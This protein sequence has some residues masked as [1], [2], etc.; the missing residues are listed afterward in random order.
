MSET[1]HIP[2]RNGPPPGGPRSFAGASLFLLAGLFV[3]ALT[4]FFRRLGLIEP[5]SGVDRGAK[6]IVDLVF[7]G[8]WLLAGWFALR[9]VQAVRELIVLHAD[10]AR[11]AV[12]SAD[13]IEHAVVP[14]LLRIAEA[15][16]RAE[17]STGL[18]A[19]V[20][21]AALARAR[22]AVRAGDWLE[23]E[24]L[25]LDFARD[26]PDAPQGAALLDQIARGRQ[27]AIEDLR[28]RIDAAKQVNDPGRVLEL[29]DELADYLDGEALRDLDPALVSWLMGLVRLGM[30]ELPLRPDLV[31]LATRIAERFGGTPEGA[32]L[33]KALPV[34]R[35]SVG[36]CPRCAQPYTG[37]DD[38]CPECLAGVVAPRLLVPVG[39]TA[40]NGPAADPIEEPP[41]ERQESPFLDKDEHF[42]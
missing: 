18:I 19:D 15:V 20:R 6:E 9:L 25:V 2:T 41:S 39:E 31:A 10:Q 7:L 16:E 36:L 4:L 40:V 22:Q 17:P 8:A 28:A 30:S 14:A 13:L 35:R 12:R 11:T 27:A 42:D 37:I 21:A 33:R 24:S 29:H 5:G 38:A 34:L 23:A 26:F 1:S 32:S 3:A